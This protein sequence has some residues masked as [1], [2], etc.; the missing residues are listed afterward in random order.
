MAILRGREV[1]IMRTAIEI[2][3]STFQVLY[4]D[5]E[6]ELAK[7][8]EL[9]FTKAEYD[10][11]VKKELPVV[12]MVDEAPKSEAHVHESPAVKKLKG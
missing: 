6:T 9:E 2:D 11:F 4:P 3:G 12:K 7:M 1:Q 10:Q 5:G 8:N